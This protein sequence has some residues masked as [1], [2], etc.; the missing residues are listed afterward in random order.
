LPAGAVR[1]NASMQ[2]QAKKAAAFVAA[3]PAM[4]AASPAMAIVSAPLLR[5]RPFVSDELSLHAVI[6]RRPHPAP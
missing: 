5:G 4:L 3:A 2:Q 1:V 6:R